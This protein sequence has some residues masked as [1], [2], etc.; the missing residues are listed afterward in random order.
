MLFHMSEESDIPVFVP[1][2][3]GDSDGAPAVV[4]AI[5]EEHL[6][7]YLFPRDCPRIVYSHSSNVSGE[8]RARFFAHSASQTIIT[9][10]NGWYERIQSATL[11]K[12]TFDPAGFAC[13]D[14]T[15]GYYTSRNT[16]RPISA[17]PVRDLV[18]RLIARGVELRFTPHLHPL[19]AAIL[20]STVDDFSI[21]RF[22]NAAPLPQCP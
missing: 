8:D 1:R 11:Y 6:V 2:R 3:T 19:K 12:Y 21:I 7:N 15:A 13:I 4:W 10:E 18:D 14:G 22:R 17:R 9:V 20:S 16:V 5:D